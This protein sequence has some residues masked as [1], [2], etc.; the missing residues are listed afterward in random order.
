MMFLSDYVSE[1][2]KLVDGNTTWNWNKDIR[3]QANSTGAQN[4]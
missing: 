1:Y 4:A 2:T 3:E